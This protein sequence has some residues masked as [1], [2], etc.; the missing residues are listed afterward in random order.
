MLE[1][2]TANFEYGVIK[3]AGALGKDIVALYYEREKDGVNMERVEAGGSYS[4]GLWH[5]PGKKWRLLCYWKIYQNPSIFS[6]TGWNTWKVFG[7]T[8]MSSHA[9]EHPQ[10]VYGY[11]SLKKENLIEFTSPFVEKPKT[12]KQILLILI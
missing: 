5:V 6:T 8:D 11:Q 2:T 9:Q 12:R 7:I 4:I 10:K 1:S 3:W